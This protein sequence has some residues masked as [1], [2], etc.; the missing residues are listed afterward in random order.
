M[1]TPKS[2]IPSITSPKI[3]LWKTWKNKKLVYLNNSPFIV[4]QPVTDT[5][6][7][8]RIGFLYFIQS[9]F[10]FMA[11]IR[12]PWF[13]KWK[14]YNVCILVYR[15]KCVYILYISRYIHICRVFGEIC[16]FYV[17]W[18]RVVVVKIGGFGAMMMTMV[19]LRW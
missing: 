11:R 19:L 3:V 1:H 2:R 10:K 15:W 9:I 7:N 16:E 8:T 5:I 4:L 14:T 17:C 13:G 12:L 18:V 6:K